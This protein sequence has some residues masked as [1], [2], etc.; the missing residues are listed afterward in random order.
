MM[1]FGTA[2]PAESVVGVVGLMFGG[3]AATVGGGV[4]G[5]GMT[6]GTIGVGG[7]VVIGPATGRFGACGWGADGTGAAIGAVTGT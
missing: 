5:V 6:S 2:L 7:I 1:T 3:V 4:V